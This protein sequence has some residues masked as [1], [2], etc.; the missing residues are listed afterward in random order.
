MHGLI[1]AFII[2]AVVMI[3]YLIVIKLRK[4]PQVPLVIPKSGVPEGFLPADYLYRAQD[5]ASTFS[6]TLQRRLGMSSAAE[7]YSSRAPGANTVWDGYMK[8]SVLPY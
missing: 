2:L 5:V 7:G 8:S 1:L 4:T 3:G 6:N